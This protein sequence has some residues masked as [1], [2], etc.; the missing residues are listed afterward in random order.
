MLFMFFLFLASL[1]S[2]ATAEPK[3]SP[4]PT[5]TFV[6]IIGLNYRTF[7]GIFI[8]ASIMLAVALSIIIAVIVFCHKEDNI[9]TPDG[10]E[11]QNHDDCP[12]INDI[13]CI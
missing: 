8:P 7:T 6:K 2:A 11:F 3:I 9:E 1:G 10:S 13:E 12:L 5:E 4:R